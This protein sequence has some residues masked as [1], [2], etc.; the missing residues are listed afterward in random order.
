MI[1]IEQVTDPRAA[2]H[3]P[4]NEPF[5]LIGR[6]LVS[7]DRG[8]WSY[9]EELF[10]EV[11][12]MTFPD[13]SYDLTEEGVTAFAAY[14]GEACVGLAILR[15]DWFRYLYVEELKVNQAYRGQGIGGRL[16]AAAISFAKETKRVG[17]YTV[18]QDNNLLACRFYLSQ[19]FAVGGFNNRSYRGT[20]QEGKADVYF[21]KD[22][23]E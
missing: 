17:L 5:E 3:F 11:S 19:G 4:K 22:C 23:E 14:D 2:V 16:L 15:E 8:V 1:R 21:Y 20:A 13:V 18:G 9:E 12:Q 6:L 10:E 7:C